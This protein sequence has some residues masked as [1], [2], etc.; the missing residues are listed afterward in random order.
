M[1]LESIADV[2]VQE[3]VDDKKLTEPHAR[4][5]ALYEFVWSQ[6]EIA[7]GHAQMPSSRRMLAKMLKKNYRK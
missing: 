6:S 1:T 2:N 3:G 7:Y 5:H 4:N